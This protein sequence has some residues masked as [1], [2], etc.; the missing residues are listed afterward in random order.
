MNGNASFSQIRAFQSYT[1]IGIY[2]LPPSLTSPVLWRWYARNQYT[3]FKSEYENTIKWTWNYQLIIHPSCRTSTLGSESSL[4]FKDK[5]K[6]PL[7][8]W[9]FAYLYN[10][11][12]PPH[13]DK[14][15]YQNRVVVN[16]FLP[17]YLTSA[18]LTKQEI[19]SPM[20]SFL[21]SSIIET[22]IFSS[23][24]VQKMKKKS[25]FR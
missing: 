12:Q 25:L 23:S 4:Y 13:F 16:S 14:I 9:P 24:F 7:G 5:K 11:T 3:S 1:L 15:F 2:N 18:S 19:P 8:I 10:I 17:L 20:Y 22:M 6:P 21:S